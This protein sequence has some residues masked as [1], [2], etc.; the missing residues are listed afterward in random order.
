MSW[1]SCFNA[2]GI[3]ISNAQRGQSTHFHNQ[4]H[5][6]SRFPWGGKGVGNGTDGEVVFP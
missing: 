4:R 3:F 2:V 6:P 5:P 1:Q